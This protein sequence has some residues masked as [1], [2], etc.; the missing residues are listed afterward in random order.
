MWLRI[1]V[2][3]LCLL[4]GRMG[5]AAEPKNITPGEVALIPEYCRDAQGFETRGFPERPTPG[6]ARWIPAMGRSFWA[7]HHYCWALV[8]VNRAKRAGVSVQDRKFLYESAVSDGAYVLQN[9]SPDFVLLPEIHLRMGQ[10]YI[11]LGDWGRALDHLNKSWELKPDYWPAYLEL[12]TINKAHGRRQ[13]AIDV[14]NAGLQQ[15]PGQLQL[16][17]ALQSLMASDRQAPGKR[18]PQTKP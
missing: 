18:T 13:A 11:A 1:A 5:L 17:E 6:Q 9:A 4:M 7:V 2:V 15:V 12:A 16:T 10:F 14:L 3:T 8:G